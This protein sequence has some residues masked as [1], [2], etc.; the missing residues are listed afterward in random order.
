[1][2]WISA[3]SPISSATGP[4]AAAANPKAVETVPS[5][6]LAP[7][8]AST[9]GGRSRAGKNVSTS[10][11]GIDDA[12]TIV[13]SAGSAV[14]SSAATR[15][16]LSPAGER[17]RAIASAADRSARRQRSSH[18]LSRRRLRPFATASSVVRGSAARIVATAPAGSCQAPSGS[19]A[20]CSASSAPCSHC[21]SGLRGRQVADPQHEVGRVRARPVGVAQQRVVVRD[22][23]GAAARAGQRIG[24]QRD[25]RPL[26]ERGERRAE[27]AVALDATGD[28]H[29]PL[30]CLDLVADA[31]DERRPPARR[32]CAAA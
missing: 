8:L 10:R 18:A 4:S 1:M 19:N 24:Q 7:R 29:R 20:I 30:P 17:A 22:G 26:G 31:V 3:T 16:S 2:S 14:P 32:R 12:T 27:P 5:I 25:R 23:G 9:R 6:P 15:G 11:T 21:R 28:Q 13:A